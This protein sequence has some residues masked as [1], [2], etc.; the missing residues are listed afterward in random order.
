MKAS[1]TLAT[2]TNSAV[3]A[4]DAS[5]ATATYDERMRLA[6]RATTS[7]AESFAN[8]A[9]A[10]LD[11]YA[12]ERAAVGYMSG[13]SEA[14]ARLSAPPSDDLA[15]L[16]AAV[17]RPRMTPA[18]YPKIADIV[19]KVRAAQQACQVLVAS[20]T[21]RM[22]DWQVQSF[23]VP[24][25]VLAVDPATALA[26]AKA[27]IAALEKVAIVV[28]QQVDIER[29]TAALRAFL[30]DADVRKAVVLVLSACAEPAVDPSTLDACLADPSKSASALSDQSLAKS[31]VNRVAA[32][33]AL[34]RVQHEA[35]AGLGRGTSRDKARIVEGFTKIHANLKEFDTLRAAKPQEG[36]QKA[37]IL[38][39]LDLQRI[40]MDRLTD[41]ER[42]VIL[43]EG[44]KRL[45]G[46]GKALKDSIEEAAEAAEKARTAI[47]TIEF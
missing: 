28:L 26:A 32:A 6:F 18:D 7:Q 43:E 31:H 3:Q 30:D 4:I 44:L 10:G 46:F 24:I 40:R 22:N 14:I 47:A 35:I 42:R 39:Y 19:K 21:A 36:L 8:F 25:E 45:I 11:R 9:C 5:N 2:A 12:E 37:L 38:A 34:P 23:D 17:N 13:F 41:A 27:L 33:I 15:K 1:G 29:R 16:W 20:A